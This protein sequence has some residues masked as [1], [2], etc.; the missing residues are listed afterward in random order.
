MTDAEIIAAC[1]AS[2]DALLAY[3]ESL[4]TITPQRGQVR[5]LRDRLEAIRGRR[6]MI[7]DEARKEQPDLGWLVFVMSRTYE[8]VLRYIDYATRSDDSMRAIIHCWSL[9]PRLEVDHAG[10]ATG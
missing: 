10:L 5:A 9:L 8:A 2:A 7:V 3:A 4:P 1:R 6:Q